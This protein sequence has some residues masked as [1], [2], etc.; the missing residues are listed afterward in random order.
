MASV[1]QKI[2]NY[3]RGISEQPDELKFPGQVQDMVNCLPDVTRQLVKRP[4]SRYVIDV[5]DNDF[6]TEEGDWFSYYRDQQEQYVGCVSTDGK[7][8]LWNVVGLAPNSGFPALEQPYEAQWNPAGSQTLAYLQHV[9][10]DPGVIQFLTVNDFTYVVNREAKPRMLAEDGA[11]VTTSVRCFA[12]TYTGGAD[13]GTNIATT[14]VTGTGTGLTVDVTVLKEGDP[15]TIPDPGTIETVT[16]NQPGTGYTNGDIFTLAAYPGAAFV[17][18]N[19]AKSAPAVPEAY[20]EVKVLAYAREYKITLLDANGD[21]IGTDAE[22]PSYDTPGNATTKISVEDVTLAWK[23]D[24]EALGFTAIPI[25]NGIYFSRAEPFSIQILDTSTMNGFAEDVNSF[26]RLPYQCRNGMLVQVVNTAASDEDNFWVVFN[27]DEDNDGN[28]SWEETVAPN[29]YIKFDP[30]RMPHQIIRNN[31]F[32]FRTAPINWEPMGAGDYQT[33]PLPSFINEPT[34]ANKD[35]PTTDGTPINKLLLF[36]NRLVFLSGEN[37]NTSQA[38]SLKGFDDGEIGLFATSVVSL[39]PIDPIDVAASSNQPATLYNG[40]EINNGLVLF[41]ETQQYL[42]ASDDSAVGL[43]QDTVK[44]SSIG[45]YLYDPNVSP[46]LMGTTVGFTNSGGTS[47]RLF[48]MSQINLEGQPSVT[49]LSKIVSLLLPNNLISFADSKEGNL[50]MFATDDPGR[51]NEVWGF[52]YYTVGDERLQQAWF[53]WELP[54]DVIYN[55]IMRDTYYGVVRLNGVNKIL[56]FDI[57][58]TENTILLNDEFRVHLDCRLNVDVATDNAVYNAPTKTTTFDIPQSSASGVSPIPNF[59]ELEILKS[60]LLED[61]P[62]GTI[63][64]VPTTTVKGK[65]TGLKVQVTVLNN[66]ITAVSVENADPG[67]GYFNGDQFV[68]DGYPGSLIEYQ[69]GTVFAYSLV[70][71]SYQPVDIVDGGGGGDPAQGSVPGDWSARDFYIGYTFNMVVNI[72]QFYVVNDRASSNEAV[73]SDT[74]ASLIIH[75][76]NIEAGASGVFTVELTRPGYDTYSEIYYPKVADAYK[77]N[78]PMIADSF[79]KI[80]PCYS[81]NKQMEVEISARHPSPFT[82]FSISWEGDFSNKFYRSV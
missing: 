37:V 8:D 2:P 10:T 25:G 45:N 80:I 28:G 60:Q 71:G 61:K 75:R 44:L 36:R 5:E 73:K 1:T 3:V 62:N 26:D 69:N 57:K 54:G 22:Q 43:T 11:G 15:P 20:V 41:G 16:I 27:G 77:A 17:Y 39:S 51:Q 55:T 70:D 46:T 4:G 35:L 12:T 81:R 40:V 65:G 7:I 63:S 79:T 72:P 74:R 30:A 42:L 24:L 53:R 6:D 19:D 47:F 82:L 34:E 66:V 31:D 14:N 58:E 13:D 33:N 21:Q 9:S 32:T 29:L 56:A 76:F 38:G 50:L 68:I 48:E 64:D 59:T 67:T 78:T 23:V 18:L 52:R 49:E